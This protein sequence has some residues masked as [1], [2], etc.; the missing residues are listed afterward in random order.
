MATTYPFILPTISDTNPIMN[1]SIGGVKYQLEYNAGVIASG[2]TT[3]ITGGGITCNS[4]IPNTDIIGDN[5]NQLILY[6]SKPH[7]KDNEVRVWLSQ[8]HAC[9]K[10]GYIYANKNSVCP[11]C[12][13]RNDGTVY[14]RGDIY[15]LCTAD[16]ELDPTQWFFYNNPEHQYVIMEREDGI[17]M[18]FSDFKELNYL[19]PLNGR[20]I[21]TTLINNGSYSDNQVVSTTSGFLTDFA[22]AADYVDVED[23]DVLSY[24]SDSSFIENSLIVGAAMDDTASGRV[25][26][27]NT[28]DFKEVVKSPWNIEAYTPRDNQ[29]FVFNESFLPLENMYTVST[30]SRASAGYITVPSNTSMTYGFCLYM[31]TWDNLNMIHEDADEPIICAMTPSTTATGVSYLTISTY[32]TAYT[33]DCE[34]QVYFDDG[35]VYYYGFPTFRRLADGSAVVTE[36]GTYSFNG[37]NNT[38]TNLDRVSNY[39]T[40]YFKIAELDI[41]GNCTSFSF[42]GITAFLD[43]RND[44]AWEIININMDVILSGASEYYEVGTIAAGLDYGSEVHAGTSTINTDETKAS[45]TT[46]FSTPPPYGRYS[47][48]LR[49]GIEDY[50]LLYA[51]A[52]DSGVVD[53]NFSVSAPISCGGTF[54]YEVIS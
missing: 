44:T 32:D 10:C 24:D 38:W 22:N 16:D 19:S 40:D 7:F 25:L 52:D 21:Y 20:K 15:Y 33:D 54:T 30:N 51:K 2:T 1:Y 26:Y 48:C 28:T 37:Y 4:S 49:F 14:G 29:C 5:F 11:V 41:P 3:Y 6:L 35:S 47:L 27:R 31:T 13:T 8:K 50:S 45:G 46:T 34:E 23:S 53:W 12:G 9:T 17:S 43:A 42:N 18:R 36:T 39:P